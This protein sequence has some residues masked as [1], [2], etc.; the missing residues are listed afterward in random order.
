MAMRTVVLE[1]LRHGP[2]HNQLLS[3]LTRYMALCGSHEA[4]D[5]S[6]TFEHEQFLSKLRALRYRDSDEVRE[7]QLGEAAV[8]MSRILSAV[9]GLIADL[10]DPGTGP[11][12]DITHLRL[13]LSANEL[14]LLPFELANSG[15]AFPGVGQSLALQPQVPICITR[16]VR[17]LGA[18]YR[19]WPSEPRILFAASS[20]GGRI[21]L[22]A[23]ML[24]LRQAI[25]PWLFHVAADDPAGVAAGLAR[26]I[27][28]LPDASAEELLDACATG[29][30]THVH[31][32]AHGV[33][34]RKEHGPRYGLVLNSGR[35]PATPDVVDA[36]R[37]ATTLRPSLRG[38]A[39]DIACPTVVTIAACDSGDIGTVVST[40]A[41]IAHALH[42]AG[43]PLV[44]GSQFPLSFA[45]SV[46]LTEVLYEGLM[47]GAD[48]RGLLV[49][50][51]RELAAR[52][53]GTHDWASVVAYAAF[54]QDLERQLAEV[55]V[56]RARSRIEAALNHADR[57]VEQ[58][59]RS[60]DAQPDGPGR[61]GGGGG[62][63]DRM[64]LGGADQTDELL[65][66]LSRAINSLEMER[67]LRERYSK[68]S[69]RTGAALA[70]I[71]GLLA[72]A[73]K[74][75]AEVYWSLAGILETRGA[76]E[77]PEHARGSVSAWARDLAVPVDS[78]AARTPDARRHAVLAS[79]RKSLVY[80]ERCFESDRSESW[81]LVQAMTLRAVLHGAGEVRPDHWL[82]AA[83]LSRQDLQGNDIVRRSWAYANFVELSLLSLLRNDLADRWDEQ[84]PLPE[85]AVQAV[86]REIGTGARDYHSVWRQL[87]RYR[88]LFPAIAQ[89]SAEVLER[90][91]DPGWAQIRERS[92]AYIKRLPR[93]TRFG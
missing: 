91:V 63:D 71:D 53:P 75:R 57:A 76:E 92:R 54:Q 47:R 15:K 10:A 6:V 83:L 86:I 56:H 27:S 82:L 40:G 21:P 26:H 66:R 68:A 80:Y 59:T 62:G 35:D 24:A 58:A 5:V 17:R 32:L 7:S 18:P 55:R 4:V 65:D 93:A 45:G 23:H 9:P 36:K 84:W 87:G 48:P 70:G 2:A 85:D 50:A 51:R 90:T 3:P 22:E 19:R 52:V 61:A 89:W 64:I 60:E 38:K 11:A 72:S 1:F 49:Q 88:S 12:A 81:A 39:H 69:P 28:V 77:R 79:L 16:E 42:E 29:L 46:V 31:I 13:I 30:Y 44:I 67:E 41:S 43:I 25:D 33:Q 78:R 20:A 37:L 14:A 34:I 74:R 73:E 8:E